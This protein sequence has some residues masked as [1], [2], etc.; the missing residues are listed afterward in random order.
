MYCAMLCL[1]EL[2]KHQD[3]VC[4]GIAAGVVCRV[5]ASLGVCIFP[6]RYHCDCPFENILHVQ[7]YRIHSSNCLSAHRGEVRVTVGLSLFKMF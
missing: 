1:C 4:V 5:K 6:L 2:W 3:C 7:D